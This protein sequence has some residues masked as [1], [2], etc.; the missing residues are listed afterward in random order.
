MM[1]EGL[2]ICLSSEA[3]KIHQKVV[4]Y[5][6]AHLTNVLPNIQIFFLVE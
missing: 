4:G 2:G 5:L 3:V 6:N 1:L